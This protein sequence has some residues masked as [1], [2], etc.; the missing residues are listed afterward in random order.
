MNAV[1]RKP[2]QT[3]D[4]QTLARLQEKLDAANSELAHLR[5]LVRVAE[6]PDA[7]FQAALVGWNR[8]KARFKFAG[9]EMLL[10]AALANA[11][12]VTE[13]G[14]KLEIKQ[15]PKLAVIRKPKGHTRPNPNANLPGHD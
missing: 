8:H 3:A 14:P 11:I 5:K 4:E 13:M 2:V 9:L 10:R 1:V 6:A 12:A 7:V 15:L